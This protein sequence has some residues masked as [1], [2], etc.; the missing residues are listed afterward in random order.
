M[1][2]CTEFVNGYLAQVSTPIGECTSYVLV[3]ADEY[4]SFFE[5]FSLDSGQIA[6]AI[7]FGFGVV[8]STYFLAYPIGLAK[9]ILNKL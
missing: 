1:A 8:V 6:T 9:K 5:V 3:T 4:A 2:I 7:G